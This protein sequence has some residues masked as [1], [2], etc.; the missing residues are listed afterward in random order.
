MWRYKLNEVCDS[1]DHKQVEEVGPLDVRLVIG[2]VAG[3]FFQLGS[4][5]AEIILGPGTGKTVWLGWIVQ[6][7]QLL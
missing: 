7:N 5:S 1:F 2:L 6:D 3:A 4:L